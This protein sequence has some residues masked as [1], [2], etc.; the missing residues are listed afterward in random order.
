MLS[1][2]REERSDSFSQETPEEVS[3]IKAKKTTPKVEEEI[4]IEDIP[5]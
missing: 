3:P 5:F 1:G 4:N 2:K